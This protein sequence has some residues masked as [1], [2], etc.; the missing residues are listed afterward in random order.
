MTPDA[1]P[2]RP[3]VSGGEA[4][5]VRRR[6]ERVALR[7]HARALAALGR[8][9]V[10]DDV[11]AVMELVKNAYD[12]GA[13]R[14]DIRIQGKG[15]G[16]DELKL[17]DDA[18]IEIEDNGH[19]MDLATI[20]DVWC[21]VGTPHRRDSAVTTVG[22]RSRAVTG[23]KG[24]G[25]L[26]AA[27]LGRRLRVVTRASGQ[28]ALEFSVDW[29]AL[30][31]A[32]D[33]EA[34]FDVVELSGEVLSGE[35]GTNVRIDALS[36]EWSE[37]KI[38]D[39]RD[40]LARL[41]SPFAKVENFA[42]RL[43]VHGS[44]AASDVRE[45]TAPTFMSE[46]KYAIR[47]SVNLQGSIR[48][49][50]RYR[51]LDGVNPRN[52]EL[53]EDWAATLDGFPARVKAELSKR[54][55]ACGP[56]EFEIRAW[57]LTRND[58]RDI[59]EHFD[60]TRKRIRSAIRSQRGL[61]VYR[62]DVLVLPKSDAARDWLG[63]D[64]R[65]VSRVGPRL[66]TSQV[67]GYVRVTRADNPE[68]VDTSDRE[69]IASNPATTAFRHLILRI[70][71]MLEVER[72]TD[73]IQG[74]DQGTAADL[75]AGLSAAPLVDK[76][77]ELRDEGGDLGAA[78]ELAKDH[79]EGLGRTRA[80]IERRFGYYNR[81]A[82]VGTIAL[83]VI[84]E[85]RN[86]TAVI[87]RGLRKARDLAK[88]VHHAATRQAVSLARESVTALEGLADRFAPLASRGYRPGRRTSIAEESIDRCIVMRGRDIR[89]AR[90]S[91]E[92]PEG[93]T[94][95]RVDPGE[96]DA[97]I[98]NLLENALYWLKRNETG[99]RLRFRLAP[100]PTS[101]RVTVAIDDSG[102][103]IPE[104]DRERVFWPGITHKPQG[105]GMGLTVAQQ[106]VH[107]HGGKIKAVAPGKLGG[108]TIEFDLP[109]NEGSG[110]VEEERPSEDQIGLHFD[111]PG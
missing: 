26:S 47:G 63:L 28:P 65:R 90:V 22:G 93:R 46:P 77:E 3:E 14:V 111:V 81:L 12:A 69:G 42:L 33:L 35:P 10:T 76:L 18:Y 101:G 79:D 17:G 16:A 20:R 13:T 50:Y 107:G 52:R 6:A 5:A 55:P 32:E 30:Q 98:I 57:D 54:K 36:S 110:A 37:E 56:F 49:E 61:S 27:R 53:V 62:D 66:S 95:V 15:Q 85:V 108:A 89:S 68:I 96:M 51:P 29:A 88:S 43:E 11:V 80:A 73:R 2:V 78:V 91:V 106:L 94:S 104:E 31:E 64:I 9:L 71:A 45:I 24:L 103:G 41:V 84:H 92:R 100:G 70:V 39:L 59:A 1:A 97:I 83:L 4:K 74:R 75:F 102:P 72:N 7:F 21:V 40:N 82:V 58:T 8:D 25:R 67:V 99:R 23:E 34:G 109:L 105:I 19:G 87:G 48:A 60:E 44:G 38:D 86:G